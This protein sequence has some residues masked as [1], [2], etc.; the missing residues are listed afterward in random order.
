VTV[1]NTRTHNMTPPRS[2]AH[3]VRSWVCGGRY[4]FNDEKVIRRDKR[5]RRRQHRRRFTI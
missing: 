2:F 3:F 5:K 1:Q 4:W